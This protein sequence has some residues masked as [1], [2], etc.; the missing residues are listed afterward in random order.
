VS[1]E[2]ES[3]VRTGSGRLLFWDERGV[4]GL[5]CVFCTESFSA[6]MRGN[7]ETILARSWV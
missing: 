1:C 2:L 5:I 4:G 7:F 3:A 6:G